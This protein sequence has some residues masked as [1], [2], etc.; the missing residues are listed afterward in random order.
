MSD[1]RGQWVAAAC[2]GESGFAS[3]CD[4]LDHFQ[5]LPD[6]GLL[7]QIRGVI[8]QPVQGIQEEFPRFRNI[9]F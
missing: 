5:I 3:I 7:L 9:L 6:V 2:P 1:L 8:P 4:T